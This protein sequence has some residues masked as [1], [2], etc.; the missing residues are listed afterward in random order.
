MNCNRLAGLW[1]PDTDLHICENRSHGMSAH[2][3]LPR[4]EFANNSVVA[5]RTQARA[6]APARTAARATPSAGV[7]VSPDGSLATDALLAALKALPLIE[8]YW[9]AVDGERRLETTSIILRTDWSIHCVVEKLTWQP[10][11]QRQRRAKGVHKAH[12]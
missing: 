8:V 10:W 11:K 4:R 5:G 6:A 7:G 12:L 1:D 2:S 3:I 9:P